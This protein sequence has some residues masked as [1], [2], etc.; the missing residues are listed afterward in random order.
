MNPADDPNPGEWR[1][2]EVIYENQVTHLSP[3][4]VN[5]GFD[6]AN[7][8]GGGLDSSWTDA[9]RNLVA[10]QLE[11]LVLD[12]AAY[13]HTQL[14]ATQLRCYRRAFNPYSNS[15]PFQISGPPEAVWALDV[16]GELPAPMPYQVAFTHTEITTYPHHWGR[17]YWPAVSF[18]GTGIVNDGIAS[19]AMVDAWANAVHGVYNSLAGSEMYAIVPTTTALGVPSRNLLGVTAIQVDDIFDIQRRR[20]R[21][22]PT[23]KTQLPV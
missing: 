15:K 16:P 17:V 20:R 14:K 2:F 10:G 23:Y 4:R 22:S 6:F 21:Y 13:S 9:D 18:S 3:D 1:R 12:W 7:I 19:Q 8:T 11:T 5:I